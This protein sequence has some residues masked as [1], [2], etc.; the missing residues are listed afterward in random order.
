[1]KI[2]GQV[3]LEYLQKRIDGWA[4]KY[5][6]LTYKA[7]RK[8]ADR[9][10]K[11]VLSNMRRKLRRRTGKLLQAINRRV[12]MVG[13]RIDAEVYAEPGAGGIQAVKLRALERGS[14]RTVKG[15]VRFLMIGGR[16]RFISNEKAKTLAQRGHHLPRTKKGY[17]ARIRAR[18]MFGPALRKERPYVVRMILHE[19]IEGYPSVRS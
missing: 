4:K 14:Y 6:Q 17:G 18:P 8:G 13:T 15:G 12:I 16:A 2:Q 11:T 5:P 1:M 3:E 7:L 19:I 10:K 9:L